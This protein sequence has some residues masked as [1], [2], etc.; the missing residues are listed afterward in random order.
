MTLAMS[1]LWLLGELFWWEA[2]AE[3]RDIM[4]IGSGSLLRSS[5]CILGPVQEKPNPCQHKCPLFLYS[6]TKALLRV[7]LWRLWA[8]LIKVSIPVVIHPGMHIRIT[9]GVLKIHQFPA[10]ILKILIQWCTV[11]PLASVYFEIYSS[12]YNVQ[13]GLR[14]IDLFSPWKLSIKSQVVN[15]LGFMGNYSILLVYHKSRWVN[16][17]LWSNKTLFTKTGGGPDLVCGL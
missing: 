9:W 14:N 6:E 2:S 4:A 11:G 7:H 16:E 3:T 13:W 1:V 5:V 8:F 12:S 17:K 10:L 15:I